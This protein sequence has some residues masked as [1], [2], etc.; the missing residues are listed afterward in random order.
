VRARRTHNLP[1]CPRTQ[2]SPALAVT[3]AALA[4]ATTATFAATTHA[5][6]A[7][8]ASTTTPRATTTT[9]TRAA[10]ATTRAASTAATATTAA[11]RA[12]AACSRP[13]RRQHA[14]KVTQGANLRLSPAPTSAPTAAAATT[15]AVVAVA[16]A[17]AAIIRASLPRVRLAALPPGPLVADVRVEQVAGGGVGRGGA[18]TPAAHTDQ[19]GCQ[20]FHR[21]IEA[22]QRAPPGHQR[23]AIHAHGS[24]LR[25]PCGTNRGCGVRDEHRPLALAPNTGGGRR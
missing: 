15:T 9:T 10:A 21:A 2:A 8:A 17:A 12:A 22:A 24:Q 20:R 13:L 25:G 3:V 11:T 23:P 19:V 14:A 5:A 4:A 16:A 6:T 7:T 18:A 1:P